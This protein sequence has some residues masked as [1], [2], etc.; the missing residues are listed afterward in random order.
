MQEKNACPVNDAGHQDEIH[1][2]DRDAEIDAK[3]TSQRD[4]QLP[5]ANIHAN[6]FA[7]LPRLRKNL[8]FAVIATALAIDVLGTWGLFVVIDAIAEDI[9]LAQGGKAIWIVSAYAVAFAACIPLGGRLCDVYPAQWWFTGAFLAV[10]CLNMGNSFGESCSREFQGPF[11]LLTLPFF[12]LSAVHE[13]KVFLALRALQ[14]IC[15][16]LTLPSGL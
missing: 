9:G 3:S 8:L 12:R 16:A 1:H 2:I 5:P 6:A 14:G 7:S 15:G 4:T 11:R 10:A 13:P